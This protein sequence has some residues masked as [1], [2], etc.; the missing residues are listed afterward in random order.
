MT[1]PGYDPL[2]DIAVII[3]GLQ[4]RSA[5]AQGIHAVYDLLWEGLDLPP[6]YLDAADIEKALREHLAVRPLPEPEPE[7]CPGCHEPRTGGVIAHKLSCQ[8]MWGGTG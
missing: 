4:M 7:T 8:A 1:A 3:A 6:A 5:S 2:P